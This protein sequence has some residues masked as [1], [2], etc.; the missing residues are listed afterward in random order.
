MKL[1]SS[2]LKVINKAKELEEE[3]GKGNVFI[4]WINDYWRGMFIIHKSGEETISPKLIEE[5]KVNAKVFYSLE[6]LGLIQPMDINHIER[7]DFNTFSTD[8]F[9]PL[10]SRIK[11]ELI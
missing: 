4:R 8:N 6:R 3:Y 9:I 2:Q 1:T 7:E 5:N 11:T 10:G